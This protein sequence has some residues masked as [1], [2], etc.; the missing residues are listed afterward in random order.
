MVKKYAC[1]C[2]NEI[3]IA[4][5]GDYEVCQICEWEDDPG[6]SQHPD[7]DLGANSISLNQ[8]RAEWLRRTAQPQTSYPE[9]V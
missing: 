7:D 5:L 6:Q 1:P 4:E 9:A 3:T 8:Y 2:C